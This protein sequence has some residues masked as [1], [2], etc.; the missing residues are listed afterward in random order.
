[1]D[2]VLYHTISLKMEKTFDKILDRLG[3]YMYHLANYELYCHGGNKTSKRKFRIFQDAN[4]AGNLAY[5]TSTSVFMLRSGSCII[6]S[7]FINETSR[8]C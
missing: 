7:D 1:M 4:I 2:G 3:S 8:I 6:G 5:S